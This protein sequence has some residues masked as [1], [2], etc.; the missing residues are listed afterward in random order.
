MSNNGLNWLN[1]EE[2]PFE[3]HFFEL[4]M[5][6]MHYIDEGEGRPLIFVH[7]TPTWSYLYRNLIKELSSQFRCIA[8]DHIGFGLSDKPK[9]W[10]YR[11]QDHA[12]NLSLLL[13]SLD[14]H[15]AVMI[16]HDFGGPIGLS[17]AVSN[18]DRVSKLIL[19]NTWM[20]SLKHNTA[21]QK[22]ERFLNSP[23]A[24]S[25]YLRANFSA[26][27]MLKAG[28]KNKKYFSRELQKA[29]QAPLDSPEH[30]HGTWG[31]AQELIGSSLW[32][33]TLWEQAR[34]L[35]RTPALLLWGMKDPAF[36]ASELEIWEKL[37][38]KPEVHRLND[39]GHFVP[40]EAPEIVLAHVQK[41]LS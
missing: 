32:Y 22:A 8:V 27:V 20:W 23:L 7:G 33:D 13:S 41:F 3:S 1:R 5:G 30:R 19:F 37:F 6:K 35:A 2:Y 25:L 17:W 21:I 28:F 15:D 10:M 31:F 34:Y 29:Y 12:Q 39:I 40:E 9:N 18:P 38:V 14:L 36:G 26:R 11:P 16:V 4:R 24:K